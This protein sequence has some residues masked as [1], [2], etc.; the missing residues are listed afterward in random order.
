GGPERG[1]LLLNIGGIANV[2][3]VPRRGETS[4]SLAFDTG[5]GVAVIDAVAR[6]IDP[7]APHA[8]G[9]EH[10]RRGQRS[11]RVL[12]VLL[13]DPF[14]AARPPKSTGR[15]QFGSEY[16]ERLLASVRQA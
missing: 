2:T 7:R 3:W 14:F 16:A 12:D 8:A 5:P 9:G 10:A 4:A 13:A 15:E 1:R 6:R 11:S